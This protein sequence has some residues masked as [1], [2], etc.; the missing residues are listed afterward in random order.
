MYM[1]RLEDKFQDA[2]FEN[3]NIVQCLFW[4][5]FPHAVR[6][7]TNENEACIFKTAHN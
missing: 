6:Q 1:T 3:L 4:H 2:V 5:A 7:I